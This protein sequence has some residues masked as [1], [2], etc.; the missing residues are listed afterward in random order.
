MYLYFIILSV[1]M[2]FCGCT[3]KTI[4]MPP[5]FDY[6]RGSVT[7]TNNV[8][9]GLANNS[10]STVTTDDS[11]I[12]ALVSCKNLTGY[13][14]LRWD[15]YTPD[16]NLY[17]SKNTTLST[18]NDKYSE[19]ASAWH[20]L[21]I[22]GNKVENFPGSWRVKVFIDSDLI[23]TSSFLIK[24]ANNSDVK[25]VSPTPKIKKP[26]DAYPQNIIAPE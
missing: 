15:W 12:S 16:G 5:Q 9:N 1:V 4:S 26:I 21:K 6:C 19:T 8:N 20:S 3:T 7:L 2:C 10:V 13:H 23:S 17:L 18:S 22:K 11:E 14:T 25:A 24:K